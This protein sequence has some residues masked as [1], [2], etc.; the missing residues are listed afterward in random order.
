MKS[1][2]VSGFYQEICAVMK[3]ICMLLF[4]LF[5][6]SGCANKPLAK[7]AEE[8]VEIDM[9]ESFDPSSILSDIQE[10]T[11]ITTDLDQTAE[12]MTIT[13]TKGDKTETIETNVIL[14]YPEY[15]IQDDIT[16][17]TYTGY[18]IN[19]YVKAEEGVSVLSEL[20]EETS[21][22]TIT[23]EKGIWTNEIVKDVTL[24]DTRPL[25]E[26]IYV[27][28]DYINPLYTYHEYVY[29]EGTYF[30]GYTK[31]IVFNDDGTGFEDLYLLGHGPVSSFAIPFYWD[32][33]GNI[34]YYEVKYPYS[35]DMRESFAG[36]TGGN[37]ATSSFAFEDDTLV[38]YMSD[39]SYITYEHVDSYSAPFYLNLYWYEPR[40]QDT[41]TDFAKICQTYDN[42]DV[43]M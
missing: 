7:L 37:G 34:N 17:D 33:D 6:L 24:I 30:S 10:G 31:V 38:Q 5:I 19:D 3:K 29:P 39:D 21:Q 14:K 2:N 35:Y 27:S 11:E 9:T 15:E 40:Y 43:H 8:P 42:G 1:R 16:I 41:K 22:L 4:A 23:L 18:D 12:K 20:N 36:L 25:P 13:L 26:G 28:T 32:K